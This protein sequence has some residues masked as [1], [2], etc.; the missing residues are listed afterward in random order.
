MAAA[1]C[2]EATVG[3]PSHPHALMLNSASRQTGRAGRAV[4]SAPSVRVV[5]PSGAPVAGVP[6]AFAVTEGGGTADPATVMSG[7]DGI[8]TSTW[9]LGDAGGQSLQATSPEV[10]GALV[11][12]VSEVLPSTGYQ[13][14]LSLVGTVTDAQWAALTSAG[15][16]IAQLVVGELTPVD[17][18][19]HFCDGT[20][21]AGTV[22]NLLVLVHIHSIDGL[23]GVLGQSGPCVVR[24][25]SHLP[26]VGVM[27]LDS[28]DLGALE[29]KGELGSVVL[30]EMLHVVGFGTVWTDF[31]PSLVS[32][33]GTANSAYTG[34]QALAAAIGFNGAPATWISVPLENCGTS[35]PTPCG[36]GTR[37]SHWL[38]PVFKNELMTGWL[39]GTTHP[40]SLTTAESFA[41]MGY[42]VDPS[43]ADPFDLATAG[44]RAEGVPAEET[45]LFMADD[46]LHLP[47][48]EAR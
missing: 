24:Q 33:A 47:I 16:R 14:D 8:A 44:L 4:A 26:A 15:G 18:T 42:T 10:P 11:D 7:T 23:G 29:A 25:S 45:G 9:T 48:E 30:H 6:V 28:A 34:A 13:I 39:S 27:E 38:E 17:L 22:A 3:G 36:S 31:S 12:L 37:D 5:D 46:V 40:L 1:S 19:G 20:P 41:D 21:L 43:T 32:G 35:S 2:R